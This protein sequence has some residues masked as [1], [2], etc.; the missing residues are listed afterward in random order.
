MKVKNLAILH[1]E[2][3]TINNGVIHYTPI[4]EESTDGKE[5]EK[6]R[7][8][9]N[10]DIRC[11]VNFNQGTIKY[12]FKCENKRTGV[13]IVFDSNDSKDTFSAGLSYYSNSFRIHSTKDKT[14]KAIGSLS[15]FKS[16]EEISIK[17]EIFGSEA[18]LFVNNILYCEQDINPISMPLTFRITSEGKVSLYDIEVETVKPKLFVV[19]QFTNDFNNLYNDVIIPISEKAGFEVIRAD[20]FYSSTPILNDIIRSI[21]EASVIIADITPDNPNVF[22]EIGYAHAIK[23]PTILICDKIREKLPFD[24]SS[25]RTLYYENSIYGKAKIEKSLAKYLENILENGI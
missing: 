23:K 18:K 17:Y 24:I 13:L 10:A 2:K 20:E 11:D 19:M 4:F 9:K 7:K 6:T 14:I 5:K 12:K 15:S 1:G 22:Y 3:T 21:K 25:F 16:N 8:P